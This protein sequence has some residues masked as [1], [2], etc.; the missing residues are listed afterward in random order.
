AGW[1]MEELELLLHPMA[2]EGKEAI[3]SMGDDSPLA[4]LNTRFKGL[5]HFMRQNFAQVT[6]PPLDS[7]RERRVMSLKTRLGNLQNLLADAADTAPVWEFDTPILLP[8]ELAQL[9]AALGKDM[10]MLAATYNPAETPLEKAVDAL[11]L[12]ALSAIEKGARAVL[13][14]D[15]AEDADTVSMPMLLAVSALNS[16]LIRK[17]RRAHAALL[18]ESSEC[19]EPHHTAML[20]ACGATTVT[21][22]LAA[23]S[24]TARHAQGLL[25]G[26][27]L[28]T[29]L[30][31]YQKALA[32]GLLKIMAKLGISVVASYRGGYNFEAIGLSRALMDKY[33]PS[34]PSRL[35]GLGIEA[36]ASR[37]E[38][39]HREAYGQNPA[40]LPIGGFYRVRAGQEAH[41]YD[42]GI[43]HLLQ[44]AVT[45][46][47]PALFRQYVDK[48]HSRPPIQV[49][50]LLEV[51]EA[52]QPMPVDEIEP[53]T[54]IRQ[55][56]VTP[57]MS[58]G[59][60][61]P[62]AHGTLN[63]AMNRIGAKSDSG[64][65]GEIRERYTRLANGDSANS[66]IKQIASARFGVTSE[67]LNQARELEIKVAQGAKPGEGGQLPGF[68][69]TE[70]IARLRHA[71]PGVM[72][73]SPPP[74]HDIYSIEDLA[75]LIY[76]L[77]QAAPRARVGVKLVARSG[78][79]TIAAGVAKANADVILVSGHNGGTGAS[80][81]SSIKHAGIPW[82]IGL[83]EVHQT[84]LLN[85]L[86]RNVVLRADG[87]LKSGRDIIVA[88]LLGAE[89]YGIGTAALVA[90]GCLMVRQCHSNTCP[91]GICTQD[92]TLREKFGGSAEK[93]INLMTFIA[94]DVRRC[95]SLMGARTLDEIIGRADLLGWR[96]GL[97]A[98]LHGL[99]LNPVLAEIP[100][101]AGKR[102]APWREKTQGRIEVEDTLD[103]QI[104]KDT[105]DS[106]A[107]GASKRTLTYSISTR[108][109]SVGA[110]L[111][112]HITE[113]FGM[114]A[115]PDD[116]FV[117]NLEG[118]AGQ[119]FGVFTCKGVTL[120]LSG[121]A[122]DYVGKGL[123]GG[124]I[125]VRPPRQGNLTPGQSHALIG[126]TCLY[127]ATGGE[128]YAAGAAGERFAV[129]NSGAVTVVEG[130]GANG[131]EYMTGGVAVILGA[132]GHNFAAGM[133]GG[134]AYVYDPE[135]R[136]LDYLNAESVSVE[137]F[138]SAATDELRGLLS[139][140]VL[141]TGSALAEGILQ[142]WETEKKAFRL[143]IPKEI[144]AL[145]IK[146]AS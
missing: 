33:F 43:V 27:T 50:D 37:K 9:K 6:N 83:A 63:I 103:A 107:Q 141:R 71:T 47:D 115:L 65:G 82:E 89:E 17:R 105:A 54:S 8:H 45:E 57:G 125:A 16:F 14:T 93:V 68:K 138:D 35:S 75:Q 99:D 133:T 128:L 117:I 2:A 100:A 118:S 94:E 134:R 39:L 60:L 31:Q 36:L 13:L 29:A 24:I 73:I 111:S 1:S 67:Y 120:S 102:G 51:S 88:A 112:A 28:E 142:R 32:D 90:M 66:A 123:C 87:G 25:P 30:K 110:R 3:G 20:I 21:P 143:L 113:K 12:A 84:L 64:E 62:E 106:F 7:I 41:A 91:V 11:C 127:G 61:S 97:A 76:D 58:L 59:A 81:Q 114:S 139:A 40:V 78:I 46:N 79:G 116:Q 52:A 42:G 92:E 34:V 121:I 119:S 69:V 38:A 19:L 56:F 104:L 144:L 98:G 140:H 122:N 77:K 126:N 136:L 146:A 4:V 85:D 135:A 26:L 44:T 124:I 10:V 86:R 72:L 5:H 130:C 137:P 145:K 74:H 129:R 48:L 18:V 49:R 22:Y 80:P 70:L 132:V 109:R 95:L 101:D 23:A 108:H 55:R 15:T 96:S 131:C 53:V